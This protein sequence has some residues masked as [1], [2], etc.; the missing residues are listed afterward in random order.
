MKNRNMEYSLFALFG[1]EKR[2]IWLHR[3][4]K[5]DIIA[6]S[7]IVT[8]KDT[9]AKNNFQSFKVEIGYFKDCVCVCTYMCIYIYTHTHTYI[10]TRILG[11]NINPIY[12]SRTRYSLNQNPLRSVEVTWRDVVHWA[13][14]WKAHILPKHDGKR[15]TDP[16]FE[17]CRP[18][19]L[20]SSRQFLVCLRFQYLPVAICKCLRCKMYLEMRQLNICL[21]LKFLCLRKEQHWPL[22]HNSGCKKYLSTCSTDTSATVDNYRW[23]SRMSGPCVSSASE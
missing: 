6:R 14:L 9:I 8:S 16:A 10:H 18:F 7:T 21:M 2:S 22:D 4:F 5:T 19:V 17:Y 23:S 12:D 15:R 1:I 3:K 11:K 20:W 13:S